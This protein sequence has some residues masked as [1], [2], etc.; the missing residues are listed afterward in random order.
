[1]QITVRFFAIARER[2]G[3][4]EAILELPSGSP[5]SAAA[6]LLRQQFPALTDVISRAAFAVN[7]SY[8]TAATELHDGDEVA[9]IPPVSGG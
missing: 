1:M 8:A 3:I 9:L 4:S 2:A 7:R 5:L 6:D